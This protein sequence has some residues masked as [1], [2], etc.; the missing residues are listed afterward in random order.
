MNKKAIVFHELPARAVIRPNVP[1]EWLS[2]ISLKEF[3]YWAKAQIMVFRITDDKDVDVHKRLEAEIQSQEQ[4]YQYYKKSENGLK[5]SDDIKL[6]GR[7]TGDKVIT[8]D[9]ESLPSTRDAYIAMTAKTETTF[10]TRYGKVTK[11][12]TLSYP[13]NWMTGGHEYVSKKRRKP[14]KDTMNYYG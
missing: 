6:S 14:N 4:L 9:L 2:K 7:L 10:E 3:N 13:E 12:D 5:K 8:Y 1:V 11:V